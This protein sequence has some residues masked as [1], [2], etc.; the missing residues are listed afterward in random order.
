M[1]TF[2]NR[3]LKSGGYTLSD[4]KVEENLKKGKILFSYINDKYLFSLIKKKLI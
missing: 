2:T 4:D 3:L 1:S